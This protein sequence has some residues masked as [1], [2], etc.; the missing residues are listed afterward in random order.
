MSGMREVRVRRARRDV[1]VR[2]SC[3]DQCRRDQAGLD[4]ARPLASLHPVVQVRIIAV[5]PEITTIAELLAATSSSR[6]YSG[7][8]PGL[9]RRAMAKNT[10]LTKGTNTRG[11]PVPRLEAP[12]Y[13][14][15]VTFE[16]SADQVQAGIDHVLDDVI[17]ALET[18]PGLSGR[19]SP[20]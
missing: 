3:A 10:L 2:E 20:T 9:A 17:P 7:A 4:S 14:Q 12:M 18:S 6:R 16:E 8:A 1:R 11:V 15:V 19:S 13:A 5:R